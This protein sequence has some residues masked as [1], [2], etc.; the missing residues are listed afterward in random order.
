VLTPGKDSR[1]D[2]VSYRHNFARI[3]N[4]MTG[5]APALQANRLGAYWTG[6]IAG[7][8]IVYFKSDSHLSQDTKRTPAAGQTLPNE[9]L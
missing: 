4:K 3:A 6:T 9:D 8:S 1:N 7:K 5:R 2:Y